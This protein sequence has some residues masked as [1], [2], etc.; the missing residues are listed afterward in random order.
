MSLRNPLPLAFL[1]LSFS[2][3]AAEP[4][5][6]V[7]R[8]PTIVAFF[9]PFT[10]ADLE[11]DPD[12]NES[13]SDFQTYTERVR[14][15]FRKAGVDFHEVYALSFRIRIGAKLTTFRPGKTKAGYYFVVPGKKPHIEYGITTD[16]DLF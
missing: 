4:T 14:E 6:F 11:A 10:Q 12:M 8:R 16:S 9:P 3:P 15:P 1:A 2:V 7:V 13:M 5:A